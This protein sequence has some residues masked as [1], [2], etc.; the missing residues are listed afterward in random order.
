[1]AFLVAL[2]APAAPL[3]A[4]EPVPPASP[5]SAELAGIFRGLLL[6]HLP[7]PLV[8]GQSNWG[9]QVEA[10]FGPR[11]KNNGVW[12]KYR[13]S[14]MS[15][16]QTLTVD[17]KN[18]GAVDAEHTT[19]EMHVGFD[20]QID[21]QQ[22]LWE[23]NLRLYSGSTLARAKVQAVLQCEVTT[24]VVPGNGPLPD[25]IFRLRVVKANLSYKDL[26]VVH[27]GG[28]GGDGAKVLGETLHTLMLDLKPSLEKDLLERA[29]TAIVKAGGTKAV[30]VSL[31]KLLNLGEAK[32]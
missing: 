3:V 5:S 17:I 24:R 4:A 29:N 27:I 1:M 15:P 22:R 7:D 11:L 26:D 13:I 23:R 8:E 32:K 20:A 18:L 12:R 14:A 19:F 30:R 25:F 9:H 6:N 21:F 2:L 31:N 28:I 10:R 16:A